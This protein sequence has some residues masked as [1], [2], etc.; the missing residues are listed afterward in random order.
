MNKLQRFA[1]Q[2]CT[3]S[4]RYS[5]ACL[6]NFNRVELTVGIPAT[7]THAKGQK[8]FE[9]DGYFYL[10]NCGDGFMG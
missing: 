5:V 2:Q 7:Y 4:Q 10:L 3:Y 8:S 1:L 6:K 9:G